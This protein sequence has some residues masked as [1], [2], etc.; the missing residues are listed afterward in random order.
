MEYEVFETR[1]A[2]VWLDE[3]GILHNKFF[4]N[5]DITL[6]D[7]GEMREICAKIT[8]GKKTPFLVDIREM[9]SITREARIDGA[10]KEGTGF[11][12]ASALLVGSPVSKAIG[13][14]YLGLNKPEHPTKLFT[15]EAEAIGWLKGF[16]E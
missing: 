14:L 15:S 3:H 13:N 16:I 10:K 6:F 11:R 1:S 2:R 8:R 5:I 7:V 4:K 9:K 12:A